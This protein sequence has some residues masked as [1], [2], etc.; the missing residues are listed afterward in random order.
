MDEAFSGL[1]AYQRIVDDIFI[2]DNDKTQHAQLVRQFLQRCAEQRI[3]LNPDKWEYA[4]PHI[5]FAGF[6]L[7]QDGYSADSSLTDAIANFPTPSD[8]LTYVSSLGWLINW[9][10]VLMLPWQAC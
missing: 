7:S 5:T 3:L 4:Q 2:Y 1:T 9:Q 10:P 8:A 6:S